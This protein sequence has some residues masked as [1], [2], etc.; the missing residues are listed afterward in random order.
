LFKVY[1]QLNFETCFVF[2]TSK[3]KKIFEPIL[4]LKGID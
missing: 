2:K 3:K 1:E 4:I